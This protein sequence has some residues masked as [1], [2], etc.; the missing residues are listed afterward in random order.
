MARA[1][2]Y[3]SAWGCSGSLNIKTKIRLVTGSFIILTF[4]HYSD[5]K[6][7][8]ANECKQPMGRL[9]KEVF[10]PSGYRTLDVHGGE[11]APAHNEPTRPL[12]E[13]KRSAGV[14]FT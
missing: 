6:P 4:Y 14:T 7:S 3:D 8:A 9:Q 12:R 2:S 1:H 11:R 13:H 5:N 10:S